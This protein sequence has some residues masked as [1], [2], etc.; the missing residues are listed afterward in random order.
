[1]TAVSLILLARLPVKGKVVFSV[2]QALPMR[3]MPRAGTPCWEKLFGWACGFIDSTLVA[4]V[5]TW[6]SC[7]DILSSIIA[8]LD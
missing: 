4:R 8:V 6:N 3:A 7:Y 2:E 5:K 1:M